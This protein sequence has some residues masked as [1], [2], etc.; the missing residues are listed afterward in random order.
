[1]SFFASANGLQIVSGTL[2]IPLV[3]AWTGDLQ[4]A[5]DQ[6]LTGQV[7]VVIGNLTMQGFV[8]RSDPYGGQTR[9]RLVG[10]YGGWRT[11]IPAQGYGS[12]QGVKLSTVLQDAAS[13]CGEQIDI[14]A[15]VTIGNAFARMS[16]GTSAASDVLWQMIALGHMTAWYVAP[17]GVTK[18]GP[19][20]VTGVTTPFIPT[21]QRPDEGV[22]VVATED[23]ASWM[24]GASF[25]HPLLEGEFTSA[26]VQYVWDN[27]GEFRFE[28][29]TGTATPHGMLDRVLG[30]LQQVVER[31]L[32]PTRYFGRYE[33]TIS[34]PSGT[35]IDGSPTDTTL[36]L[37]D[38]QN[39][40]LTGDSL[41]SYTPPSGGTAHVQFVN[42]DPTKPVCVWTEADSS[43]GPTDITIA[44]GGSGIS[45]VARVTD[46]CI[47]MFPPIIQVAG[48]IAG[49]PFIGVATI[50]T[51]AVGTIQTGSS[52][53][54]AAE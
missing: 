34:N 43:N 39:V 45:G 20:P 53:V 31:Q 52:T 54:Q 33:Y 6:A 29:L 3:G 41:A 24:P 26:G 1:M 27:D 49:A 47:V 7:E 10:G 50:T 36:G 18:T 48:T 38:V 17:S 2:L 32:A 22:V 42:G 11:S 37:P 25:T 35:T 28:V 8:V 5:T 4:L 46:T 12:K 13:A 40:P 19:W 30:P 9:A 44:P 23:Y 15:D 16:F 51:P 21:D 14:F